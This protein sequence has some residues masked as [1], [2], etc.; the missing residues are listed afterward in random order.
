M[1]LRVYPGMLDA[2]IEYFN[3][4]NEVFQIHNGAIQPF[5]EVLAHPFLEEMIESDDVL[6]KTLHSMCE[7]NRPRML[8]TLASC[9]FGGLNMEP[10]FDEHGNAQHDYIDCPLRGNC[11]GDGIVCLPPEINGHELSDI[12]LTIL[13]ECV[14]DKKNYAIALDLNMAEGTFNVLKNKTYKSIDVPNKQHLA[15]TLIDKGLV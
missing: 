15:Q 13:R 6:C 10:D 14:S 1:T 9:R 2:R 8:K 12:E 4:E 3:K 5:D 11:P 7:G